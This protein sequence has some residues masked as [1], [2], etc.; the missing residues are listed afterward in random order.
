MEPAHQCCA[1]AG[2]KRKS[3]RS[4]SRPT[5][6]RR[7]PRPIGERRSDRLGKNS[8]PRERGRKRRSEIRAPIETRGGFVRP[9]VRCS[10][11]ESWNP[12]GS[13][14]AIKRELR[15]RETNAR[16]KGKKPANGSHKETTITLDNAPSQPEQGGHHA[17]GRM[18]GTGKRHWRRNNGF[19]FKVRH[20][21][22]SFCRLVRLEKSRFA[23][24]AEQGTKNREERRKNGLQLQCRAR[25]KT[26][27]PS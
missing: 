9:Q 6:D 21:G 27:W 17:T 7:V 13:T 23:R 12:D 5:S 20:A 1:D 24:G 4:R 16:R 19:A 15:K 3:A 22:H 2:K 18:A 26:M 10:G 8:T 25:E 11:H 14:S